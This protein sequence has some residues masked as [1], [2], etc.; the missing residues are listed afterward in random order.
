LEQKRQGGMPSPAAQAGMPVPPEE[1][2]LKKSY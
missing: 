1:K 2:A